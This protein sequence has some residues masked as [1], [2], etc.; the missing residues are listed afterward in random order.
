MLRVKEG[1]EQ[2]FRDL[3][4]RYAGRLVAFADRFFHNRAIAEE[5]DQEA[6]LRVHRARKHYKPR[7]RFQTWLYTIAARQAVSHYRKHRDRHVPPPPPP[8]AAPPP[9][10][11]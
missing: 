2:A 5:I 6:F 10:R 11:S 7:A 4:G 9:P 8:D 3:F 1:D